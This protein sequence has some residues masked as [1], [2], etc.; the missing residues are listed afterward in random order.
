MLRAGEAEGVA[1]A[2]LVGD[3]F[4][5]GPD[6]AGVWSLLRGRIA[7]GTLD[8]TLG[9]HDQR[10]LDSIDGKRP[11]DT[12]AHAVIAALDAA[13][14][15]WRAWLRARPLFIDLDGVRPVPFVVVHAGV[16]PVGGRAGTTR[17]MALKMRRW[18][19]HSADGPF[20]WQVYTGPHGVVYGHDAAR[21]HIRVERDG[22]PWIIGLDT[23]CVYGGALT[24]WLIEED[25]LLREPARRAYAQWETQ[26]AP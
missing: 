13:D 26:Q 22:E 10:L 17:S 7:A 15:A 1:R 4:T 6:P 12:H 9:N 18:P 8:A 16:H 21:G 14:P 11:D 24:G 25:R 23:G 19:R 2:I 3:L 5:R 20:W